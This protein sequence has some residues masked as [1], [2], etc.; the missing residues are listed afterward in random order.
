MQSVKIARYCGIVVR[1]T[2]GALSSSI[3]DESRG[4]CY[5]F[6]SLTTRRYK[7]GIN[8]PPTKLL[9]SYPQASSFL[10][11]QVILANFFVP[12]NSGIHPD[13]FL[14]KYSWLGAHP[15]PSSNAPLATITMSAYFLFVVKTGEPHV[16]QKERCT[17][18]PDSVLWSS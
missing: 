18:V 13:L 3:T 11:A 2:P 7:K 12:S 1:I 6:E 4:V 5:P 8:P 9:S 10:P 14:Q 15:S 16:P 17:S